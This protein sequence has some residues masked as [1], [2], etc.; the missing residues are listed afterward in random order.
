MRRQE[1]HFEGV[2]RTQTAM[3]MQQNQR[4]P[5]RKTETHILKLL[6]IFFYINPYLSIDIGINSTILRNHMLRQ[7][8]PCVD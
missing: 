6:R 5:Y 4:S 8:D 7:A 3:K 2:G 1:P